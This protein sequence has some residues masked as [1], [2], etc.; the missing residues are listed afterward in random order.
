M[1]EFNLTDHKTRDKSILARIFLMK[2][3]V[4]QFV[5]WLSLKKII[6][7]LRLNFQTQEIVDGATEQTPLSCVSCLVPGS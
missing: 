5:N 4:K 7:G 2:V 6:S 3:F 1:S